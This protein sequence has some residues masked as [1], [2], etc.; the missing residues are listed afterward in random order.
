MR[1]YNAEDF[2]Y[3][4]DSMLMHA[5][6]GSVASAQEWAEE[7]H[8]WFCGNSTEKHI[9]SCICEEFGELIDVEWDAENKEWK[10][11]LI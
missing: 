11:K 6:T 4:E 3:R 9:H 8:T 2:G 7:A 10:E 5:V 1:T